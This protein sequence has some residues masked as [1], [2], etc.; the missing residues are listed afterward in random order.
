MKSI[1]G[2]MEVGGM[3]EAGEL[4]DVGFH[5]HMGSGMNV[6]VS[7]DKHCTISRMDDASWAYRFSVT[8]FF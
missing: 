3:G 2:S 6:G 8:R 4:L 1:S 5:V 7:K